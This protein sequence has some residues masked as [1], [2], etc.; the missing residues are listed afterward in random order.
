MPTTI[1]LE[2]DEALVLFD[3][4]ASKKLEVSVDAPEKNALWA[5]ECLLEK[6]LAKPFSPDY[7]QLLQK[8]S[9]IAA[10]SVWTVASCE[11]HLINKDR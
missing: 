8:R 10:Q 7:S 6:H 4:L 3:L 2:Q 9:S 11:S 5:L 1:T